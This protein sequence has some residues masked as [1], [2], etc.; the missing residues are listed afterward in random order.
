MITK[1]KITLVP[2]ADLHQVIR[3]AHEIH[4]R[5][6]VDRGKNPSSLNAFLLGLIENCIYETPNEVISNG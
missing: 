2:D 4:R 5:D 1:K 3:M 6:Q